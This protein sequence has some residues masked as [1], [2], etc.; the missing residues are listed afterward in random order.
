MR[1]LP[2]WRVA[3]GITVLAGLG[4][5]G[6]NLTPIYWSNLKLQ[7]FVE[8]A[9]QSRENQ[10]AAEDV[11]RVQVL[12]K[13]HSLGLPVRSDNVQVLRTQNGMRID[14]RYV[15]PVDLPLYT[16]NLHFY[17]GAGRR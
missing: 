17:P 16:V 14:V 11:I 2:W 15:A 4:Y 3:A 7:Q 9:A 12:E 13:A 6:A 10:H 5:I 8:A 1:G